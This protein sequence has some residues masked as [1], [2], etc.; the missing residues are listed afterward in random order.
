MISMLSVHIADSYSHSDLHEDSGVLSETIYFLS[1]GKIS[2]KQL[3]LEMW[4]IFFLISRILV[5]LM[6]PS[7]A[8]STVTLNN[9]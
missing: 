9:L 2:L 6:T 3:F 8:F 4:P 1:N 7:L 5:P